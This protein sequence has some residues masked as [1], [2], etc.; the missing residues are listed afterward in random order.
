MKFINNV[1]ED[2]FNDFVKQNS[3]SFMQTSYFG[4]INQAKGLKYF[5]VGLEDN[6]KLVATAMILEK[7][8]IIALLL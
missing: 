3:S 7:H 5:L 4:K 2:K 1:D 8:L 6:G